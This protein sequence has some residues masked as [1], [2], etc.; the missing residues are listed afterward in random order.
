M[1][2]K[3]TK[4]LTDLEEESKFF[5][6]DVDNLNN[7]QILPSTQMG[8]RAN[9]QVDDSML[10]KAKSE[11]APKKRRGNRGSFY[12]ATSGVGTFK[13]DAVSETHDIGGAG[14]FTRE[15]ERQ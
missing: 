15:Q 14:F 8:E 12:N 6:R 3:G 5:D 7:V 9:I 1:N 2:L 4:L 11:E 13:I 10:Q